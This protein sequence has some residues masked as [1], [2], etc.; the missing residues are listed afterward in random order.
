MMVCAEA[1]RVEVSIGGVTFALPVKGAG[2]SL[3]ISNFSPVLEG[4]RYLSGNTTYASDELGFEN[5]PL[6]MFRRRTCRQAN[7]QAT[8]AVAP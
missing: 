1:L 5:R 6:A 8:K 7:L 2:T 3:H 4:P